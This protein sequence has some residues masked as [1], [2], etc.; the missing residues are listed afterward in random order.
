MVEGGFRR[1]T[2]QV[3]VD[4]M[5][6]T[7]RCLLRRLESAQVAELRGLLAEPFEVIT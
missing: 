4:D 7:A 6:D 2:M 3:P 1:R 5:V